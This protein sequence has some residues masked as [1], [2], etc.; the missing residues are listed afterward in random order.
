MGNTAISPFRGAAASSVVPQSRSKLE[1]QQGQLHGREQPPDLVAPSLAH[2]RHIVDS[3]GPKISLQTFEVKATIGKGNFGRVRMVRFKNSQDAT[4]FALK[5]LLKMKI[6]NEWGGSISHAARAVLRE[7][8]ILQ[9]VENPFVVNVL[10]I[11]HT[12]KKV[13]ILMEFVNGGEMLRLIHKSNGLN[14][15]L[16]K[17]FGAEIVITMRHLHD[18]NVC[19]RDLKPEN[20]LLDCSGH[21]KLIDFGLAKVLDK[22]ADYKTRTC[23]GTLCY[24]APEVILNKEYSLPVD[25]W[26]VGAFIFEML[27]GKPPFGNDTTFNIQ[28]RILSTSIMWPKCKECP[29]ARSKQLISLISQFLTQK[30]DKRL[31]CDRTRAGALKI[32]KHPFF[33]TVH[34]ESIRKRAVKPPYRP[35]L[36]S[37]EDI[38]MFPKYAESVEDNHPDLSRKDKQAWIHELSMPISAP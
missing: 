8:S 18:R 4:P 26:G 14:L 15:E 9:A 38:C 37:A 13:F 25:W 17:F 5:I 28:Q 35:Q 36:S 29:L 6:A 23:C 22:A 27:S 2:L 20:V 11:F 12:D 30:S 10:K 33:Q 34:F 32:E 3:A 21:I 24:Q 16:I 31:G 1:L 7:T 19:Y